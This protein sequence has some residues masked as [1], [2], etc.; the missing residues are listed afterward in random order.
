MA[1][2]K[3][4]ELVGT[5]KQSWSDAA[6]EAVNEAA[7]TVRGIETVEVA[8]SKAV[9]QNNKLTEYQVLVRIGF[10][11]EGAASTSSRKKV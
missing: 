10:R 11:I 9:V 6:R 8:Q 3:I 4:L 5:S 2:L 7:K 1:V